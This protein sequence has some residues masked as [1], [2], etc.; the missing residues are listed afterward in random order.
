[1]AKVNVNKI[2]STVL[3]LFSI[4]FISFICFLYFSQDFVLAILFI[5]N[6][7]CSIWI[8]VDSI[9]LIKRKQLA[10]GI[11]F[12][13]IS[14]LIILFYILIFLGGLIIGILSVYK[15]VTIS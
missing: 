1:M 12:L 2:K 8:F 4:V 6:F 7:G 13:V 15:N 5:I 3:I 9:R 10:F 14:S 11:T